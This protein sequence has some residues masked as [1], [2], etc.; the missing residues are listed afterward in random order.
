MRRAAVFALPV[1]PCLEDPLLSVVVSACL[2]LQDADACDQ[3]FHE[4]A[5]MDQVPADVSAQGTGPEEFCV[6]LLH[7]APVREQR[8]P[9]ALTGRSLCLSDDLAEDAREHVAGCECSA[10]RVL[11]RGRR[12]EDERP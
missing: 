11:L 5:P 7:L 10:S 9:H 8:T 4:T 2:T 1:A 12:A 6:G 3:R